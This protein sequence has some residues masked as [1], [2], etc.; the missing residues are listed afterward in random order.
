MHSFLN[1]LLKIAYLFMYYYSHVFIV[2][3]SEICP[4]IC[5]MNHTHFLR[6]LNKFY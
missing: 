6:M 3:K 5:L 4:Q 2:M 1:V